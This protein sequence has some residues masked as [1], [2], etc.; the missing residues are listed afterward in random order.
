MPPAQVAGMAVVTA[1]AVGLSLHS[2][3]KSWQVEKRE[4]AAEAE[5]VVQEAAQKDYM[6]DFRSRAAQSQSESARD[7]QRQGSFVVDASAEYLRAAHK[8]LKKLVERLDAASAQS[9][10]AWTRS[11]ALAVALCAACL[12]GNFELVMHAVEDGRGVDQRG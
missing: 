3:H 9:G 12:T 6:A 4:K 8:E 11:P 2:Q 1:A 7:N 5:R 10:A